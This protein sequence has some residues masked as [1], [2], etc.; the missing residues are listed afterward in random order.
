[1]AEKF[2]GLR[3]FLTEEQIANLPDQRGLRSWAFEPYLELPNDSANAALEPTLNSLRDEW[4]QDFERKPNPK[5]QSNFASCL[6]VFLLNLMRVHIES[7]GL[8]VG[9][10]SQKER[11][12][13]QVQYRPAFMSVHYYREALKLL[14]DCGLVD[15]VKRGHRQENYGETS[16]YSLSDLGLG[17]LPISKIR[18]GDFDIGRRD[19]VILLKDTKHRLIRYDQTLETQSMSDK[20]RKLNDLLERSEIA[21]NRPATGHID[22]DSDF[23]G[24]ATD[25]YRVFNNSD[26]K[27]GGRFYGGW[28]IHAKKHFRRI[29]TINGE[30]TIEA[31]FKGIHPAILFAKNDLPIPPDP[32]ALIPGVS[33]NPALRGP[34]KTTFLALMNAGPKGT[35]EPKDFNAQ[36]GMTAKA[37]QQI[38]RNA[39]PMLPGIFGAGQGLFLQREDSDLAE[40]I[41]MHFADKG[42]TVLPVHDSFIVA[43]RHKDELVQV[44]QATFKDAYGQTPSVT[45]V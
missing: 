41:M 36:H 6:R 27:Q 43:E 24:Q 31:D 19:E 14:L 9:I 33:E 29:I 23:S 22:F 2:Q 35:R 7:D 28:W 20:L 3:K 34:A 11:L 42:I 44:M 30:A 10:P 12:G 32:Y 26:F 8:T 37:F 16:R 5:M 13:N 40:R 38:V 21:K 18:E 45:V 1:M 39:F 17:R 15:M 25:L 4:L